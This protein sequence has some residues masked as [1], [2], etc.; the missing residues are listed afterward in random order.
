[1]IFRHTDTPENVDLRDS[2]P[3]ER[4]LEDPALCIRYEGRELLPLKTS[5][6]IIFIQQKYLAPMD[7]LKYLS[8]HERRSRN[9][10]VYVAAKVGMMI[11]A[12]IMPVDVVSETLIN[13]LE[14]L[15]A[16]C[17]TALAKKALMQAEEE[18]RNGME[19]G[20]LFQVDQDTGEVLE[21]GAGE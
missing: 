11:Q 20:T 4:E 3:A 5:E 12:I 16:Q 14:G 10:T 13:R 6:G 7:S 1:M 21:E 9:G 2:T 8:L 19:Q 15:T 18:A 17:R